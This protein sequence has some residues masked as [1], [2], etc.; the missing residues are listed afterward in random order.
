MDAAVK[1]LDDALNAAKAAKQKADETSPEEP[2]HP[3]DTTPDTPAPGSSACKWC[4]KTHTGF[5]G[6]FVH[7]FHNIAYLFAHLFGRR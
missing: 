3:D 1:A 6:G 2:D 4:G 5:W 7:F